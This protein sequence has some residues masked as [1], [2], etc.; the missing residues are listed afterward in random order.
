MARHKSSTNHKR[1]NDSIDRQPLNEQLEPATAEEA[2]LKNV[3]SLEPGLLTDLNGTNGD[4]GKRGAPVTQ[5][6]ATPGERELKS[7]AI[8]VL[9]HELL[10]PL[11]LIKGYTSTMLQLD[12]T[13]DEE[14]RAQYL[15]RIEAASDRLIHLLENLRDITWLEETNS[16]IT[17]PVPLYELLRKTVS[18]MQSQTTK[19]VITLHHPER[20]PMARVDPEKIEQV[21]NNLIANAIKYS[22]Q[23]GDIE[24]EE[25][26]VRD[27]SE[28]KTLFEKAPPVRLPCFIVSVAD[29]G[30]G[31][32]EAELERVFEKFYRV[33]SRFTKATPGAGLGLYICKIIVV[34]HGGKIWAQN[35]P[36]GGSIFSF[37]LPLGR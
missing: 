26:V 6:T 9:S 3:R 13:L 32:P 19:N 34:A 31:V 15:H 12:G 7:D 22:P 36:Q 30:V 2:I 25:K 21:M 28:L 27:E 18:E 20:L 35:R 14:K 5:D 37:S 11:T 10:S 33:S 8:S 24:V 4:D 23:G 29:N 17:E 1:Q 16:L